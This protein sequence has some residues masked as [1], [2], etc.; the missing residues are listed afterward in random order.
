MSERRVYWLFGVAVVVALV[1]LGVGGWALG[2][3]AGA[4]I[5]IGAGVGGT[6]IGLV[7]TWPLREMAWHGW[8]KELTPAGRRRCRP[9]LI[10]EFLFPV[11]QAGGPRE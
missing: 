11:R 2:G 6:L 8:W 7:I 5:V 10:Q 4:L 3:M 9:W 1:M